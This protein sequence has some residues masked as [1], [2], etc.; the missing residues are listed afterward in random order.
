MLGLLGPDHETAVNNDAATN[1][2]AADDDAAVDEEGTS[3]YIFRLRRSVPEE[4]TADRPEKR[5][6]TR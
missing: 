2:T 6:G 4:Q 3:R 5:P 1:E